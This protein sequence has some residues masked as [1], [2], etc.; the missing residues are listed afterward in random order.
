MK[1]TIM[2]KKE[3]CSTAHI[4]FIYRLFVNA[5]ACFIRIWN[6]EKIKKIKQA[7]KHTLQPIDP[8]NGIEFAGLLKVIVNKISVHKQQEPKPGV[9]KSTL[10]QAGDFLLN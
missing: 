9:F 6:A 10:Y 4:P 3:P 5:Q 8:Y 2:K 1:K 7:N